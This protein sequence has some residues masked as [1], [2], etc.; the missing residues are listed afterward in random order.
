MHRTL[1]HLACPNIWNSGPGA[2]FLVSLGF[3]RHLCGVHQHGKAQ[4]W[5]ALGSLGRCGYLHG[6]CW[7]RQTGCCKWSSV[8]LTQPSFTNLLCCPAK[9]T[10]L[11][12]T[13][14]SSLDAFAGTLLSRYTAKVRGKPHHF[15]RCWENIIHMNTHHSVLYSVRVLVHLD[16][17]C[18]FR[19][20][21][22]LQRLR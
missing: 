16:Q 19:L 8:S 17:C 5:T 20:A 7:G 3:H 14:V 22:A 15:H 10:R 18:L 1:F 4:P 6:P 11:G 13:L 21:L 2:L 12:R 9:L